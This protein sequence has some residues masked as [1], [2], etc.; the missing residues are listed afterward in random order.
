MSRRAPRRTKRE[1]IR[2]SRPTIGV[3][4]VAPVSPVAVATAPVVSVV[5]FDYPNG[6][7]CDVDITCRDA[8]AALELVPAL[9]RLDVLVQYGGACSVS[10]HV[11]SERDLDRVW[12]VVEAANTAARAP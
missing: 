12:D 3:A 11:H 1:A 10:L 5:I 8:S 7:C 4:F 6:T 2:A 9:R